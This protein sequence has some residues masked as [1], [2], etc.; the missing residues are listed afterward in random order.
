MAMRERTRARGRRNSEKVLGAGIAVEEYGVGIIG[1]DPRGTAA[2][3]LL[4]F[5][6]IVAVTVLY[7]GI[8]IIPGFL[9]LAAIYGAIDRPASFAVTDRGLAVLARSEFN[10][11]PRKVITV[12]PETVLDSPTVVRSRGFVHLPE[13]H[14]WMRKKEHERLLG[15]ARGA[16]LRPWATPVPTGVGAAAMNVPGGIA[17]AP[18]PVAFSAPVA[19][20]M[21][22]GAARRPDS[23]DDVVF[24]SWCGKERAVNAQAIHYCGSMERPAVFCMHCGTA[25]H[26]GA[27]ACG[28]CGTPATQ[29]SR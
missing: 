16:S 10:G 24:C 3:I 21:N 1:P 12:L 18:P 8:I 20:G 28:S 15:A 9:L 5:A 14:L 23:A 4:G 2:V 27:A 11:R 6:A 25:F 17:T 13:V 29:L 22:D 19:N 26:E 7:F